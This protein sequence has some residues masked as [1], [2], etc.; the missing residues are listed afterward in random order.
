MA[1]PDNPDVVYIIHAIT[2]KYNSLRRTFH[3]NS[4][5]EVIVVGGLTKFTQVSAPLQLAL[6]IS[7]MSQPHGVLKQLFPFIAY[8]SIDWDFLIAIIAKAN[9]TIMT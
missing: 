2:L 7:A 6:W 3:S 9:A 4:K 5:N 1:I 8:S